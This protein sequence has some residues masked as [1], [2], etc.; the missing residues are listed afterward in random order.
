MMS[1]TETKEEDFCRFLKINRLEDLHE[2]GYTHAMSALNEK[3][4]RQ[5]N[6]SG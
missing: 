4:K 3:A 1:A 6:A 5:A 2:S